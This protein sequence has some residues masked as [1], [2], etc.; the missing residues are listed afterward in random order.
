MK[1]VYSLPLF[2][3]LA[4]A[5]VPRAYAQTP[6]TSKPASNLNPAAI[7]ADGDTAAMSEDQLRLLDQEYEKSTG[8][9]AHLPALS[10]NGCERSTCHI[11]ALVNKSHQTLELYIDG[12]LTYTWA[13]STARKGYVTPDFDRHPDGRIYDHW[14]SQTFP[15]GDYKGLGNMP[16]AVFIQGGFAIHGVPQGEWRDLGKPASHGCVRIHPDNAFIFNRLVRSAG[17]QN[18]WITVE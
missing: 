16:Y 11:Y 7:E 2:F 13:T 15:G 9:A 18:T 17:V 8:V 12:V 6:Q 1:L 10:G 3:A 14:M 5:L 4:T